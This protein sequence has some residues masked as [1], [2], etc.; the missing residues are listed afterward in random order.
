MDNVS[1]TSSQLE[2]AKNSKGEEN[3]I[4]NDVIVQENSFQMYK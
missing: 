1:Q 3:A 4:S 2:A